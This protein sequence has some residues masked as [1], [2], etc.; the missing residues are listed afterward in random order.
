M[1]MIRILILLVILSMAEILS[2]Q[3]QIV[4]P[5]KQTNSSSHTQ[6]RLKNHIEVSKP[7][8]F[9]NGH[10]YVDLGLTSGNL[11]ATSNI[12]ATHPSGTGNFY[13]WGE[14]KEI[15][16]GENYINTT[17]GTTEINGIS[18]M[19][20]SGMPDYDVA[21]KRWKDKWRI[22]TKEDFEEL[23]RECKWVKFRIGY[24]NG[25]KVIGRNGR[26]I[27][28]PA[29]GCMSSYGLMPKKPINI[30]YGGSYW[31]STAVPNTEHSYYI[32]PGQEAWHLS[33][34]C[35][36]DTELYIAITPKNGVGNVIRPIINLKQ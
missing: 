19:D 2:A 3:G 23:L 15:T 22:P 8:G 32:D 33:F 24:T 6:K 4:R 16:V 34:N 20:I 30:N 14:I 27:F 11:W 13:G 5:Q 31:T 7:D 1:F 26:S 21:R 18:I 12:G 17:N 29:C 28:F 10:G 36:S 25:Y 35:R 9:V